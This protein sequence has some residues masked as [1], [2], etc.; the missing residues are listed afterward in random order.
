MVSSSDIFTS[1]APFSHH[2]FW[3]AFV[4]YRLLGGEGPDITSWA[5]SSQNNVTVK[6][7]PENGVMPCLRTDIYNRF[8]SPNS[9]DL[10][11]IIFSQID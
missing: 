4:F 3:F 1:P 6:R 8:Y 11:L 10:L 9:A 2:I 5:I 7:D